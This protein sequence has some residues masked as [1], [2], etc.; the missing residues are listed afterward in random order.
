MK[1]KEYTISYC[2]FELMIHQHLTYFRLDF[3]RHI[4]SP[5]WPQIFLLHIALSVSSLALSPVLF[6]SCWRASFQLVFGLP[7]FPFPGVSILNTFIGRCSSPLLITCL[8][9]FNRLSMISLEAYSTLFVPRISF[10]GILLSETILRSFITISPAYSHPL[11]HLHLSSLLP[12]ALSS[13]S[14]YRRPLLSQDI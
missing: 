2:C 14:P 6:K 9:Q 1:C 4:G 7:L 3:F 8:Y 5:V 13:P 11:C 10:T 12:P